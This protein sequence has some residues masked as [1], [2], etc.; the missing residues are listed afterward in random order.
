MK[1]DSQTHGLVTVLIP[2]GALVEGD[3]ETFNAAVEEAATRRSGRVVI[4]LRQVPYLD[5]AGIEALLSVF[6]K[7]RSPLTRP[8][9][10]RLTDT[11]REAL[12]LT[13]VLS[14]LDVYDTVENAIR[15]Y[16]R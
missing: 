15:S 14:K 8:R 12:D 9:I 3:V 16:H 7:R 2:N 10:A 4:D 13:D 5:S 1:I 6:S 11:C